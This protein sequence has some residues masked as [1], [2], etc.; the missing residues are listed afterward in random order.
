[1]NQDFTQLDL[2]RFIYNET[3]PQESKAIREWISKDWEALDLVNE[4]KRIQDTL[5]GFH[6]QPSPTSI[7]IIMEHNHNME[8]METSC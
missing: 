3:L 2:I 5:D 1:M 6:A 7:R 4:Y 8:E